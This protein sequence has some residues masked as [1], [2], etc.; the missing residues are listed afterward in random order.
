MPKHNHSTTPRTPGRYELL[1]RNQHIP[2]HREANPWPCA[3]Q[4][5]R[6]SANNSCSMIY[7]APHCDHAAKVPASVIQCHSGIPSS[8][9]PLYMFIALP[10]HLSESCRYCCSRSPSGGAISARVVNCLQ[11]AKPRALGRFAVRI[12]SQRMAKDFPNTSPSFLYS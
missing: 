8:L 2:R 5:M 12:P 9:V 6:C 3:R 11:N 10:R 7:S 4:C 1:T